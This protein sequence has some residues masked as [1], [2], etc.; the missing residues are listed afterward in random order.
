[1]DNTDISN[2][3][4]LLQKR[5]LTT[6][7]DL[8]FFE[9][10]HKNYPVKANL[11]YLITYN[12]SKIGETNENTQDI[13]AVNHGLC[14][15]L[16]TKRFNNFG[17]DYKIILSWLDYKN[18]NEVDIVELPGVIPIFSNQAEIFYH[19]T[20]NPNQAI[21]MRLS[22]FNYMSDENN[23]AFFQFQFGY[24]LSIGSKVN[25]N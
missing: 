18:F 22:T 5:F 24:K 1:M 9:I 15:N 19:P 11:L 7:F 16:T 6:G 23:N 3:L 12:L 21:F 25:K 17:F 13:K 14:I 4:D 10:Y 8:N 2:P 20:Q